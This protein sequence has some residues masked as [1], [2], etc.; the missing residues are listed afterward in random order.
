MMTFHS[1][2]AKIHPT[3]AN[4]S[5]HSAVQQRKLFNVM[6]MAT[7]QQ[8]QQQQ[9]LEESPA[10]P[11]DQ[12]H[13]CGAPPPPGVGV[14]VMRRDVSTYLVSSPDRYENFKFEVFRNSVCRMTTILTN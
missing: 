12:H 11:A 10:P 2:N 6:T 13:S 8:Q 3:F 9:E 1:D 14:I 7:H 5:F 4:R